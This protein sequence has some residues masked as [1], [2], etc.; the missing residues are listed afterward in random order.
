MWIAPE[1]MA[2]LERRRRHI[3]GPTGCG[4]CGMDSLADAMRRTARSPRRVRG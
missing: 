4:L 3:A 1:R 2:A